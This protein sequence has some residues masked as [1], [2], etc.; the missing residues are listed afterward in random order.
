MVSG[1][2]SGSDYAVQAQMAVAK[3]A[4]NIQ[5]MEGQAAVSLIDQ[6]SQSLQSAPSSGK[7]LLVDRYA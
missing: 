4:Q 2:G 1:I 6:A 7:G 5:K 3:K